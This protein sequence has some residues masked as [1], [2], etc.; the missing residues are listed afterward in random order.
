M[1]FL[2][3]PKPDP[4]CLRK[5]AIRKEE[6]KAWRACKARVKKRDGGRCRLG[7]RCAGTLDPHHI[8]PR[9]LGGRDTDRN[10]VTL[11]RKHHDWVKAGLLQ[12]SGSPEDGFGNLICTLDPR[13]SGTGYE[14]TVMR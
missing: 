1:T 11:C 12:I 5:E 8:I 9:S 6:A 2:P 3:Q 13:V 14:T 4:L 10:V 7:G